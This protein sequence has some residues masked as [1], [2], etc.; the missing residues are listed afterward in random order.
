MLYFTGVSAIQCHECGSMTDGSTLMGLKG[1]NNCQ[2]FDH[3]VAENRSV[4]LRQCPPDDQCCF[5]LREHMS[6]EFWGHQGITDNVNFVIKVQK[7]NLAIIP[8]M[9]SLTNFV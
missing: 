9:L 5:T 7:F 2:F 6:V 8:V 4:Y 1:F 3:D